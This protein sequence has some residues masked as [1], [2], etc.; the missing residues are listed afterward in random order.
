MQSYFLIAPY[1]FILSYHFHDVRKKE[2]VSE[3]APSVNVDSKW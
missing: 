3:T 2:N 1:K